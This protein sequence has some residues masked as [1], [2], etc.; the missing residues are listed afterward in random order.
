MQSKEYMYSFSVTLIIQQKQESSSKHTTQH[1]PNTPSHHTL[2]P[3]TCLLRLPPL[4]N[5]SGWYHNFCH[6]IWQNHILSWYIH[7][8]HNCW[9]IHCNILLITGHL[10]R[11]GSRE[12]HQVSCSYMHIHQRKEEGRERGRETYW[13]H[14]QY[15]KQN[16]VHLGEL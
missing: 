8:P 7:W 16:T 2:C 1:T 14:Q 6:P 5:H 11:V 12:C 13:S 9:H 4:I 10:D 3:K 15:S